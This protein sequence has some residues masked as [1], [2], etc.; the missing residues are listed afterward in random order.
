MVIQTTMVKEMMILMIGLSLMT[1]RRLGRLNQVAVPYHLGSLNHSRLESPSPAAN[2]VMLQ[3]YPLSI[4]S[5]KPSGFHSRRHIFLSKK[6]RHC[7]SFSTPYF[8]FG[9]LRLSAQMGFHVRIVVECS[10]ATRPSLS[11]ADVSALTDILDYRV[12][13]PLPK[14]CAPQDKE[15]NC[16]FPKPGLMYPCG[17]PTCFFCRISCTVESPECYLNN[18]FLMDVFII[19]LRNGFKT[20]CRCTLYAAYPSVRHHGAPVS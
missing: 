16:N 11:P 19:Q 20:I 13:V 5:T 9:I 6:V 1:T 14:L 15:D 7:S 8:F 18:S 2:T 4:P 12:P 3:D 17:P 10:I